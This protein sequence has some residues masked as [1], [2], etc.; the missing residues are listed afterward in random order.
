MTANTAWICDGCGEPI[1]NVA[2]GWVEWVE[3]NDI[4]TGRLVGRDLRL[5]HHLPASPRRHNFPGCQ[6]D[7]KAEDRRDGSHVH[8]LGLTEFVGPDGLMR[9]LALISEQRLP[10]PQV[11]E[12]IKRLH[13]P[14]YEHARHHFARA[15]S[16]GVF[17]P[18][19]PKGFHWQRDIEATLCFVKERG[20]ND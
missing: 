10:T 6:F 12:L 7:Q 4:E 8:D 17:E 13:I 15:I 16:A 2:D 20:E 19:T 9:A 11:L 18:N 14:G 3:R 5:V 1:K